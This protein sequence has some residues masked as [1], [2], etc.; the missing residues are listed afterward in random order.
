MPAPLEIVQSLESVV[1]IYFSSVR[2]RERSAFILCDNMVEMACKTKA[3][4]RNPSFNIRGNFH[5]ALTGAAVPARLCTKLKSYHDT[6][7]NMQ[8]G[9]AAATVD[10]VYCA[11]AILTAVKTL[12]KLW[13]NTSTSQF[14]LWLRTAHRIIRLYSED[15]D[16]SQRKPFER[17]MQEQGWRGD[18]RRHI[19]T[20]EMIIEAGVRDYW[21]ISIQAQPQLVDQCLNEL[22]IP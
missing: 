7:N 12:D 9:N 1:D 5:D 4:Q 22:G 17:R 11:T 20:S 18:G 19:L 21:N 13:A 2:H 3:K 10:G 8:H 6:R 16:L 14:Q 15:G